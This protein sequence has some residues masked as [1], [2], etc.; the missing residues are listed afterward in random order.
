[1]VVL[2]DGRCVY[3]N[4]AFEQLSGYTFPELTALESLFELVEPEERGGGGAARPPARGAR[5]R[6]HHVHAGASGAAT[7]TA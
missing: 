3:A 5:S 2:E 4:P 1:M 6:R 7:A